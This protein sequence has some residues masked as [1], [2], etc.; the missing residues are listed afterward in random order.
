MSRVPRRLFYTSFVVQIPWYV[1]LPGVVALGF[2]FLYWGASRAPYYPLKYPKGFW[3]VQ[4]ELGAE[5]VWLTAGDG[6]RLHGWWI[7]APGQ[8]LAT[9]YLHGN[10]GNVTHRFLQMREVTAA[11]PYQDQGGASDGGA[12]LNSRARHARGIVEV[13]ECD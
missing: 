3:D 6:T 11:G 4:G 1:G 2:G 12:R 9:V 8:K 5:D 10:A 13:S 7:G